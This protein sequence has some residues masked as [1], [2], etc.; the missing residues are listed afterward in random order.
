[1]P[2]RQIVCADSSAACGTLEIQALA[3]PVARRI[4]ADAPLPL[5]DIQGST[6]NTNRSHVHANTAY[7][8]CMRLVDILLVFVISTTS[9]VVS[10]YVN[11]T[12]RHR[13]HCGWQM[14]VR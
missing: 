8:L 4:V 7:G 11:G 12:E 9:S 5:V 10:V 6:F 13:P 14:L 3:S 2:K 1:M